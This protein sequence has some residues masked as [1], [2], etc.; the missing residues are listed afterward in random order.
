MEISE[1]TLE[2]VKREWQEIVRV[3]TLV[4][5]EGWQDELPQEPD[6]QT[7]EEHD[8]VPPIALFR[9]GPELIYSRTGDGHVVEMRFDGDDMRARVFDSNGRRVTTPTLPLGDPGLN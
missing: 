9:V 4:E 3:M 1:A 5:G 8:G 6:F 2:F 7:R